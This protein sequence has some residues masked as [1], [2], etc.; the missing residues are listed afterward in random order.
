MNNTSDNVVYYLQ[1]LINSRPQHSIVHGTPT[2]LHLLST[3][4]YHSNNSPEELTDTIRLNLT[5]GHIRLVMCL[6][7]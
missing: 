6:W 2:P 4:I 3:S 5:N 7:V 1:R